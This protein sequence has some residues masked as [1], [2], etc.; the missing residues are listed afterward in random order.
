LE[1]V[2]KKIRTYLKRLLPGHLPDFMVIGVQKAATTSLHYYLNQHPG[3]MGSRPKEV[4]FFDRDEN[5]SKGL[6]WYKKH[7]PNLKTLFKSI[8][9]FESTPEYIYRSYVPLRLYQFNSSLKVIIVLRDPTQRAFSAWSMYKYFKQRGRLPDALLTGYVKD[10]PNN[11]YKEFY[12]AD[13]FPDFRTVVS[14]EIAKYNMGNQLEEPGIVRRGIYYSQIK[15]YI[16]LFG[17]DNV[18]ILGFRDVIGRSKKDTLNEILKFLNIPVSHWGFLKEEPRNRRS[19]REQI[20]LD[21]QEMLQHFYEP[22]N[23]KLFELIG[24]KP[25]W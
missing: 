21:V 19:S 17:R 22:H 2:K 25:N 6:A 12:E 24:F 15:R 13:V 9:Y 14:S 18:L 4:R 20:P 7:F 8:Q 5:Y 16:D 23:N 10:I 3:L 1:T 11:I